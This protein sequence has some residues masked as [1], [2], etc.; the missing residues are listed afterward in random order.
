FGF[1]KRWEKRIQSRIPAPVKF[2]FF[3]QSQNFLIIAKSICSKE[4]P[5]IMFI[6][7]SCFTAPDF[8]RNK[9]CVSE[10]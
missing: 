9:S 8:L 4:L 2:T 10:L 7:V 5:Y 1:L 3:E 6:Y